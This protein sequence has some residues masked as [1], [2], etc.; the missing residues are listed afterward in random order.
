[1]VDGEVPRPRGSG[2]VVEVIAALMVKDP[3]A[4]MSLEEVRRRLRPIVADPDDLLYPGLPNAPT[5]GAALPVPP[6]TGWT[7]RARS[8]AV[9][10]PN[11]PRTPGAST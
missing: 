4:R 8:A 2:P 3:D 6:P 1:M 7:G 11:G 9:P 5:S 10:A